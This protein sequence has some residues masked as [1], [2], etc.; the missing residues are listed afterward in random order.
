MSKKEEN[1]PKIKIKKIKAG[2]KFKGPLWGKMTGKKPGTGFG[3]KGGGKVMKKHTGGR[4][5]RMGGAVLS[6]AEMD[7]AG[8]MSEARRRQAAS[9]GLYAKKGGKV[10]KKKGG[11]VNRKHGSQIGTAFV[12]KQYARRKS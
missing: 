12:A 8:V 9:R 3:R 11:T 2:P 4:L 7:R 6:P 5:G 10:G 1:E